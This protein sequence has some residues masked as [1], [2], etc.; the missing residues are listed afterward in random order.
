MANSFQTYLQ[1]YAELILKAGLDYQ[2]GLRIRIGALPGRSARF[3][4]PLE[5]APL[6]RELV[7]QAYQLGAPLV[8]VF[9]GDPQQDLLRYQ[10]A[11]RDSF[12]ETPTWSVDEL[13]KAADRKDARIYI[14]GSDPYKFQDIDTALL[15]EMQKT[16]SETFRDANE[17]LV[18]NPTPWIIV[19]YPTADWSKAV[20]PELS[21]DDAVERMSEYLVRFYRLDREDPNGYWKEHFSA[22]EKRAKKLSGWGF[23]TIHLR[24]PAT[25]LKVGLAQDHLWK[26][27]LLKDRDGHENVVNMPSEEVFT[28]PDR[29]RVDGYVS[30]TKP[31]TMGDGFVDGLRLE[32]EN[33][34]VTKTEAK[35][36]EEF[37]KKT[38]EVDDGACRLGELALV[39]HSSPIS[40]AG[41]IF[42][43]TLLDEN[44][45][46]HIALG[47]GIRDCLRG[48][49]EMT[50]EE[51]LDAGGNHSTVHYDFMIGSAEMDIDG[52]DQDGKPHPLMRGG[53][54]AFDL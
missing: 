24:G 40:Q 23:K 53:E 43:N 27:A 19:L 10:H 41:V 31:F 47:R 14:G 36:G 26:T 1:Q 16:R 45:S 20:F 3:F 2:S 22:L 25:D 38:L 28:L 21:A 54:W 6:V 33:G 15:S 39:P 8:E 13:Y 32:F 4:T 30:S 49:N 7:K 50:T 5:A 9:W 29:M 48:S 17:Y 46:C 52:I 18:R 51:F 44:A 37:V 34:A 11:P 35:S 42:H 12:G